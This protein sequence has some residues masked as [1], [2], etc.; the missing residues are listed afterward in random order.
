[1]ND[2][3]GELI[4]ASTVR[5]E[6]LLPGPIERVW[7][8]LVD[9]DKRAR[10]LCG[11]NTE[12]Q[13]G[14]RVEMHFHNASLSS[15]ADDDPP[16]RYRDMPEKI[17]FEGRVIR[18][19]PPRLL[20]HTWEFEGDHSEVCYELQ[21]AGDAVRLVLTHRRLNSPE[22]IVSVC[23]GWHTHLEILDCV[24]NG[25]EP[26]AF[27]KTHTPLEDEYRERLKK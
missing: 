21:P 8:Y 1:M 4:D 26:P 13:T 6:R 3:Y 14:G 9:A 15:A 12:L 17:S 7:A 2:N 20:E 11:G 10:W 18:C 5:F 25:V 27:W 23:G 22:E 24:L 16:E 19:E